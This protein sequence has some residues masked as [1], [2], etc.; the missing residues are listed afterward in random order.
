VPFRYLFLNDHFSNTQRLFNGRL[1]LT[2][3]NPAVVGL[4]QSISFFLKFHAALNW[5]PFEPL[6]KETRNDERQTGKGRGQDD[7]AHKK[8]N[9]YQ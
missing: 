4:T 8:M 9:E 1:P 6:D 7:L 3:V 5:S 2:M